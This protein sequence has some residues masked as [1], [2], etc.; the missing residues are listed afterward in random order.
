MASRLELWTNLSTAQTGNPLAPVARAKR[1]EADGWDGG[2]FVDTQCIANDAFM[3]L[4]LCAGA[5]SRL[6]LSTGVT[7]PITRHPSVVAG[8][9]ATLQV[10]SGGRAVLGIGRGDSA[11][12][13]IGASPAPLDEFER[14]LTVLQRYLGGES[15]PMDEAASMLSGARQGY[16]NLALAQTLP[17]SWLKWLPEG[18]AKVPMEVLATGPRVIAIGARRA[19]IVSVAVGADERRLAWAIGVAREAAERAGRDPATIRFGALVP[20]HAHDDIRQARRHALGAVSGT[21]RFSIMNK[22]IVGPVTA[23]QREVLE[24]LAQVYDMKTHGQGGAQAAVLDDA[25]ID[26]FAVVGRPER[27]LERLAAIVALGYDRLWLTTPLDQGA[28][29]EESY[30]MTVAEVIPALRAVRQA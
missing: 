4:A 18:Y 27:C 30:R 1:I 9:A 15:V 5:T 16:E 23:H 21:A 7:N 24:R 29:G 12:A 6:R 2:T 8:A 10:L 13:Y 14:R 20:L 17:G 28:S 25:F 26:D 22:R 3:C 11:L 19:E